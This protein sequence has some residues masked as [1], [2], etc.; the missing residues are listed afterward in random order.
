V[1]HIIEQWVPPGGVVLDPFLGSGT[2]AIACEQSG[3]RWLGAE[4][5]AE[6]ASLINDR[7][8]RRMLG[9]A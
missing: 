8:L 4:I 3:R 9:D 6:Y 1:R 7:W 5:S 2:T